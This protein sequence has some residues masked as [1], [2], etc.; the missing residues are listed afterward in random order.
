MSET[1]SP[2]AAEVHA[3]C[4]AAAE[5]T[6]GALGRSLGGSFTVAVGEVATYAPDGNFGGAGLVLLL[7]FG[8]SAM[9]AVLPS[10]SGLVPEW[11]A[12]PDAT[13]LS[14]LGTLAQELCLLFATAPPG[15]GEYRAEF[16]EDIQ[17]ALERA[18][19]ATDATMVPLT[20]TSGDHVGTLNLI[21]PLDTPAALYAD[22]QQQP[23]K[24]TA[25][26]TAAPAGFA[27]AEIHLPRQRDLSQL[28]GYSRSLLKI[29]VPV[30][31]QLATKKEVVQEVIALAPGSI[32][33]FEKGCD[34]LLQMIVGEQAVA[35]GEAV[36]IGEKFGFRVTSMLLPQEHFVAVRKPRGA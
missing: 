10:S 34:E 20:V 15:P 22:Q 24:P 25:A 4:T 29:R 13:G 17:A 2:I 11:C 7:K 9:A 28:P 30:C 1:G 26:A 33:K 21:W 8:D 16:V 12:A 14:K 23:A 35:E 18:G 5:E 36:K 6:A 31:V 27:A 32:I 19:I 3:V